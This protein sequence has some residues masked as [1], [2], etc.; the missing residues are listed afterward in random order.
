MAAASRTQRWRRRSSRSRRGAG[1]RE[2]ALTFLSAVWMSQPND[3]S[4][5]RCQSTVWTGCFH[6][7]EASSVRPRLVGNRTHFS[8]VTLVK[9]KM[10]WMNETDVFQ[11]EAVQCLV[12]LSDMLQLST[13]TKMKEE[14]R[15]VS[16]LLTG[17]DESL[18]YCR[19]RG[20]PEGSVAPAT[21]SASYC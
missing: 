20:A 16:E 15:D 5:G 2:V 4:P 1:G 17:S 11:K 14:P 9:L 19:V 13:V 18:T 21:G 8:P 6:S 10:S 3:S 12:A 7:L